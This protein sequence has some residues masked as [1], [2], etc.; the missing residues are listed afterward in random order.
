LRDLQND[1]RDGVE[2]NQN[3]IAM[4]IQSLSHHCHRLIASLILTATLSSALAQG[5]GKQPGSTTSQKPAQPVFNLKITKPTNLEDV[6]DVLREQ[7]PDANF[8]LSPGLGRSIVIEDIKIHH[9]NAGDALSA[10]K[11]ASGSQFEWRTRDQLFQI[12]PATG[13]PVEQARSTELYFLTA[14]QSAKPKV[15]IE[16]FNLSGYLASVKSGPTNSSSEERINQEIDRI[17]KLVLDTLQHYKAYLRE[18][19][20]T[21]KPLKDPSLQFHSG[22]N[23]L[24]VMGEPDVVMMVSKI[25]RALPGVQP[26]ASRYSYDP[27]GNVADPFIQAMPA[28]P[29]RSLPG[30]EEP[31]TILPAPTSGATVSH[32]APARV[33][34]P[35]R[36]GAMEPPPN[37]NAPAA[38]P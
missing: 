30:M 15:Q 27:Y 5:S 18:E 6:V 1:R 37:V 36:G 7:Y 2:S 4:R 29:P 33:A 22:A 17:Q 20:K 13:L 24:V 23:L 19:L 8:V 34:R 12:D 28:F 14:A 25:I 11:I 38:Q 26:T 21:A 35:T 10:L 31:P 32:P 9:L 16:A 3:T